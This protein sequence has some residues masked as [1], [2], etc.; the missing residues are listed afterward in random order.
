[1]LD[2][3]VNLNIR[4]STRSTGTRNVSQDIVDRNTILLP[5]ETSYLVAK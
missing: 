4:K 2:G 1:M 3:L 5:K